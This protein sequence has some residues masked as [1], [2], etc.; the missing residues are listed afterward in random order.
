MCSF[1]YKIFR[2]YNGKG[3]VD[4]SGI[5]QT[6]GIRLRMHRQNQHL[7]MEQLAEK[8]N[9]SPVYIGQVERGEKNLT[10]NSLE[11]LLNGLGLTFPEFFE[12]MES[13]EEKKQSVPYLCYE[14]VSKHAPEEQKVLYQI[15]KDIEMLSE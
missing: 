6:I 13:T 4:L 15:L 2:L 11:K 12:V 3:R 1:Y 5:S 8:A 10:V 7:T 9:V 14:L